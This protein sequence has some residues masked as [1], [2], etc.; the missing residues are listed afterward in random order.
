MEEKRTNNE[1]TESTP[2]RAI[3]CAIH[4]QNGEN[5]CLI[6]LN[7]L[8]RLLETAGGVSLAY[9]TQMREAPDS[10]TVFGSGKVKE[11]SD[12]CTALECE[13]VIF[14]CELS[15]S[16]I[17]EIENAIENP[18][19][20]IDRSMLILDIFADHARTAEGRLQVELA[21]LRYTAPRLVGHG[22]ELSRLGGAAKSN[23]IGSR[24][25]GETKLEID[26]RRMKEKISALEAELDKVAKNRQTMRS[27]RE[28]SGIVQCGI[29]G[30]TNAGKSTLL[31]ALTGAGILAEDKLFAT[32][33]TTTKQYQLPG[34]VKILLTDT[35]GF[36][37]NLPHH[38]IKAFRSTLEEAVYS[39]ILMIVIDASDP[40]YASQ[41]KVTTELLTELGAG[42]KPIL[43]VFNKCDCHTDKNE[44][45][46][47][48]RLAESTK[49]EIVFIS[50]K[51]GAGLDALAEK[52]E[53]MVNKGKKRVK[54][55][56]PPEDG[57]VTG[58]IYQL[59][60]DVEVSYE[61]DGI[62]VS[63]TADEK[64]LGKIAKYIIEE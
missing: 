61:E 24:G 50:A 6:S 21:Q 46:A 34:G 40:E 18:V 19:Q 62:H 60:D 54:L 5:E 2:K 45:F 57:A 32:L 20:V 55:F 51:T 58:L 12:M 25:P 37:R 16:Q 44:L 3:L 14:D 28:R 47:M 38:L 23:G 33:D 4:P 22:K 7:E 31:N 17:K 27:Q 9:M 53:S 49:D 36:I 48:R 35:V 10:K 52:L 43:Y 63:V 30:Y 13:L 1:Q 64:L 41:V 26:R 29:V 15:P 59:G 56:I 39:D 8:E 42:D 11:L